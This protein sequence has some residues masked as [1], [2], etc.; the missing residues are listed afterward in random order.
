MTAP[1]AF[2]NE[3]D[4]KAAAWLREL[5]AQG[6]IAQGVVDERSI[7]D[8]APAELAGFVQCHFFAGIG[9]WSRALRAA[10]WPD[11]RPIWSGSCP[12]QPF[13][14]AGKGDGFADERHLWPH[15]HWLIQ[16]RRPP[17]VVGEQVASKDALLW[18]D[19]VSTDMEAAGYAFGAADLCA[20]GAGLESFGES[21]WGE[22]LSRAIHLCPDP[23]VA[24]ALRDFAD[25]ARQHLGGERGGH[26][27]RQRAYFVGL[28]DPE[29]LEWVRG[30]TGAAREQPGSLE[31]TER[32]RN[33]ERVAHDGDGR[34]GQARGDFAATWQ[35][36]PVGN[37]AALGLGIAPS[38]GSQRLQDGQGDVFGSSGT[39][40]KRASSEPVGSMGLLGAC[41]LADGSSA[42]IRD[43][44]CRPDARAPGA[45]KS[46]GLQRERIRDDAGHGDDGVF[47]RSPGTNASNRR[48]GD[49][50]W[51]LCRDGKWRAVEPGTFPLAH[52]APARVGRLR[53]YGNALDLETAIAWIET[54]K[55]HLDRAP[56]ERRAA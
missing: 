48:W 45:G 41:G 17:V 2:Y 46:E 35:D 7:S 8:I 50:D 11:D 34:C 31:R 51:L 1:L 54:V 49:D 13:S 22:R 26:H 33:A 55:A 14:A 53:G 23:V 15:W 4:P 24:G 6:H 56:D 44:G 37:G 29:C 39:A 40:V 47:A 5:I 16:Q 19:L 36:G 43:Q 42:G 10:G 3:H 12:C 9:V 30:Q 38:T 28:A 18:L 20:A 21:I 32:L 27:I 25:F 52:A